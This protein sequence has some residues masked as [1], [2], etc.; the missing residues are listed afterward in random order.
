LNNNTN[1]ITKFGFNN[2]YKDLYR[3]DN[4]QVESDVDSTI[5][6]YVGKLFDDDDLI[7]NF[8]ENISIKIFYKFLTSQNKNF[9]NDNL[10]LKNYLKCNRGYFKNYFIFNYADNLNKFFKL[11][12]GVFI[13]CIKN[14]FFSEKKNFFLNNNFFLKT[15]SFYKRIPILLQNRV[16]MSNNFLKHETTKFSIG[17]KKKIKLVKLKKK[18]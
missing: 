2:F 7:L 15:N 12:K 13:N 11:F 18:K 16:I 8:N 6:N 17:L 14:S 10:N 3:Q 1:S 4:S 5:N 9:I